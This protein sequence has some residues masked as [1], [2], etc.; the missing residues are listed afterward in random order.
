MKAVFFS[1]DGVP[2]PPD[3]SGLS[4]NTQQVTCGFGRMTAVI[5][6]S[7]LVGIGLNISTAAKP[8]L[9]RIWP[10]ERGMFCRAFFTS[11]THSATI[12]RPPWIAPGVRCPGRPLLPSVRLDWSACAS[13]RRFAK[14]TRVQRLMAKVISDHCS[15][16]LPSRLEL[17][18]EGVLVSPRFRQ[19]R[20]RHIQR[21]AP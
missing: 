10:Y 12:S 6:F 16:T 7:T 20:A 8:Y 14:A 4:Q 15:A 21:A 13:G 19:K 2:F 9:V 3:D 17:L 1:E 5:F 18:A 11:T